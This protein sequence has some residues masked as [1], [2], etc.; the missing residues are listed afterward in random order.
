[1]IH[2]AVGAIINPQSQILVA[3]RLASAHQGGLWEFPGGKVEEGES[4]HQAL[5]RELKEELGIIISVSHHLISV[6]H[7]Y[8]EKTVQLDVRWVEHFQGIPQG[9]EGQQVKWV[10]PHDL[11][12]LEI[13][14]ANQ[15]IVTA[16][17]S[18]L[19]P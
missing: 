17:Q 4:V 18:K 14:A 6:Q 8:P 13:P 16:I 15:P 19:N 11:S 3:L 12:S 2:V 5:V 9:R 10:N 7:A 1:M